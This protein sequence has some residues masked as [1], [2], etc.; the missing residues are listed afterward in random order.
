MTTITIETFRTNFL[1]NV[2]FGTLYALTAY[3]YFFTMSI[4]PGYVP[5]SASRSV[6]KAV[7]DEL[8]ELRQFDEHH[9]CVHCMVRKPL[10]SKH[11]KR[12][13]RCVAKSDQYVGERE[14]A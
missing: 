11:C 7:I 8:M 1:L 2:L 12:C 5:K 13:D 14:L 6:S 4:D 10:R 9:F 3:F